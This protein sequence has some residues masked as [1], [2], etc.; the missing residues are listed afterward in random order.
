MA[1]EARETEAPETAS[2]VL[3]T[4]R[5]TLRRFTVAEAPF[6]LVLLNDPAWLEFIGDKGV[7]TL[8]D[9]RDYLRN[10]PIAMYERE[11]FGLYLV[12]RKRGGVPIGMCG[13][14][15]RA[16]LA[17]VD[18]GFAFLPEHRGQGYA[19]EATAA[20]LAYGHDTLGLERI[21]AIT[22]PG[23]VRSA[24]LLEK[25]G[26]KPEKAVKLDGHDH[27]VVLYASDS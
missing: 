27:E 2:F 18:V 8:E 20:V 9:A 12:L 11:G 1:P 7:R 24:A 15:K 17:D 3:A 19:H 10:G 22:S 5:L 6:I 25:L 26:M 23:N 14:I 4:E 13:L 16:S 21:V